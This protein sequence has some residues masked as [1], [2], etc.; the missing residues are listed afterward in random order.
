MPPRKWPRSRNYR[1]I[2]R[3]N[4]DSGPMS[5]GGPPADC[6]CGHQ[7]GASVT[8]NGPLAR[9]NGPMGSVSVPHI[10]T[11]AQPRSAQ[12]TTPCGTFLDQSA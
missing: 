9:W 10:S 5:A 8:S 7:E 11:V 4:R 1:G 3:A 12:A 2:S 6:F